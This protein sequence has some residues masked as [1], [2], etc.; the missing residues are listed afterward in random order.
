MK[1]NWKKALYYAAELAYGN[2]VI[3]TGMQPLIVGDGKEYADK[4]D[5]IDQRVQ[6]WL[7]ESA[8]ALAASPRPPQPGD[9]KG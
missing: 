4:K 8:A 5:W 1:N 3:S 2:E 7:E 6:M 9:A